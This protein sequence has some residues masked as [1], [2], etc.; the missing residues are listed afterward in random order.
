MAIH[1]TAGISSVLAASM[2]TAC[3]GVNS[4]PLTAGGVNTPPSFV[5][6]PIHSQ[7][8]DGNS[9]DLLTAG[10][11]APG[12]DYHCTVARNPVLCISAG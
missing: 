7:T 2:L 8:Y 11:G 1:K 4:S 10:L 12:Q 9:D 5:K 3:A 6:G